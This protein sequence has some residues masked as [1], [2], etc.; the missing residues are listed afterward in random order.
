M[1]LCL[2]LKSNS[3]LLPLPVVLQTK[4]SIEH[5]PPKDIFLS[6]ISFFIHVLA[7]ASTRPSLGQTSVNRGRLQIPYLLL[8]PS[9][10]YPSTTSFDASLTHPDHCASI[11]PRLV[12]GI[13]ERESAILPG[14]GTYLHL[15]SSSHSSNTNSYPLCNVN[16]T[17]FAPP[18]YEAL[19]PNSLEL[20]PQGHRPTR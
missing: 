1:Q 11:S 18:R 5:P 9:S 8:F 17:G 20:R 16:S 10:L 4:K 7:V 6:C 2:A 15:P 3:A 14:H 13:N 12:L 19:V